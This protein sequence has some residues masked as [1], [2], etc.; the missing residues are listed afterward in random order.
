MLVVARFPSAP[1]HQLHQ[2]PVHQAIT[3]NQWEQYQ[4]GTSPLQTLSST[5]PV[6]PLASKPLY[7]LHHL[8]LHSGVHHRIAPRHAHLQHRQTSSAHNQSI[9]GVISQMI[10]HSLLNL[11]DS[12]GTLIPSSSEQLVN[13]GG[14]PLSNSASA[15]VTM[16]QDE[17]SQ[18]ATNLNQSSALSELVAEMT[19]T[20]ANQMRSYATYEELALLNVWWQGFLILLYTGTAIV[21]VVGNILSVIVLMRGKRS[22]KELRFFLVN[23]ALG[24]CTKK[25]VA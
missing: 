25:I 23:L 17:L 24:N 7:S 16:A 18:M 12:G 6:E 13:S 20:S 22:S 1:N 5:S 19:N 15:L 3:S 9:T 14:Q 2:R 8:W 11:T 21:A 4:L 10:D